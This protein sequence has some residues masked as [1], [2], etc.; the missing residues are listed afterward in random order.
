MALRKCTQSRSP[1]E[2]KKKRAPSPSNPAPACQSLFPRLQEPTPG[3]GVRPYYEAGNS[4]G[5]PWS[6]YIKEQIGYPPV[7]GYYTKLP[8]DRPGWLSLAFRLYPLSL[9]TYHRD[10]CS[11]KTSGRADIFLPITHHVQKW[12]LLM[13]QFQTNSSIL[14]LAEACESR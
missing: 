4:R 11:I 5:A 1:Q 6:K 13:R 14:T 7:H 10:S 8:G 2:T 9:V 3:S 12:I